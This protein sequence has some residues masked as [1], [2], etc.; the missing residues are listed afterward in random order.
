[1]I[2]TAICYV[3]DF[4]GCEDGQF[5]CSNGYCIPEEFVCDAIYDCG[6]ADSSDE[7]NCS[8]MQIIRLNNN[9]QL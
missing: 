2:R 6:M 4:I 1:M 9:V 3:S 8:S 7:T 5:A